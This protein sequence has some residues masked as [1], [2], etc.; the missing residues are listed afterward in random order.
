MSEKRTRCLLN[1][2]TEDCSLYNL[3]YIEIHF[4]FLFYFEHF[5][6]LFLLPD[7]VVSNN[8]VNGVSRYGTCFFFR[9][10]IAAITEE[11]K[12]KNVWILKMNQGKI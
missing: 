3:D 10:A 6:V 8:R 7:K 11:L 1:I 5:E 9:C 2:N 4:S 12:K